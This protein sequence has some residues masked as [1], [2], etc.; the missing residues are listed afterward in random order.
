MGA[1]LRVHD[2]D[3]G[4]DLAIK[5]L[6]AEYRGWADL[7]RRFLEEAQV[8]AQL[9]HPGV[10]PVHEVG[11]LPDGRPYFAMK[12]V[13]GRTLAELPGCGPTRRTTC[14]ASCRSSSRSARRWPSP[15]AS[16]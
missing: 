12:L 5:M 8:A 15:T 7:E 6:R 4:R 1:V 2:P 16:G 11:R 14:R 3:L 9:Q 13:Q 10:A